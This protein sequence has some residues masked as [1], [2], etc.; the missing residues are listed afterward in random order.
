[1]T[2]DELVETELVAAARELFEPTPAELNILLLASHGLATSDIAAIRVVK[3][4]T[5]KKQ[6]QGLL[7]KIG[8]RSLPHAAIL[9]LRRAL[10]DLSI[11]AVAGD[12]RPWPPDPQSES[13]A[14]LANSSASNAASSSGC[15]SR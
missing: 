13:S 3:A 2:V 9:V 12:S 5:V 11:A 4:A 10:E 1:M 15:S 8:A 6:V 14:T 7:A